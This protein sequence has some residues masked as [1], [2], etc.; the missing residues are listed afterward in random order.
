MPLTQ[1]LL[2]LPLLHR[3][4]GVTLTCSK[5][6]DNIAQKKALQTF[7]PGLPE[8]AEHTWLPAHYPFSP[9]EAEACLKDIQNMG[10]AALSGVPLQAF[11]T[12]QKTREQWRVAQ[13]QEALQDFVDANTAEQTAAQTP[14][15]EQATR[16]HHERAAQK[17]LLWAWLMEEHTLEVQSLT[18]KYA[19]NAAQIT[20]ALGVEKDDNLS[21]L[22]MIQSLLSSTVTLP[23]WKLVMENMALFLPEACT[24]VI[25]H[26]EMIAYLWE[27]HK[28]L[29]LDAQDQEE[30]CPAAPC[31]LFVC[32]L[33]LKELLYGDKAQAHTKL[34]AAPWLDKI[35]HCIL[36][37]DGACQ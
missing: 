22:E 2:Y 24:A 27:H 29:A 16:L 26:P 19:A 8:Q 21:G 14:E 33:S 17:F 10:Q 3:N 15:Q 31:Q 11:M 5:T 9:K 4:L 35:L 7:W 20:D 36:T 12:P 23:P 28:P 34:W 6:Q 1:P 25:T 37:K 13:E 30:L 32:S 18:Q